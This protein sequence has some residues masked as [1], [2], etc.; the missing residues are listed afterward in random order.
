MSQNVILGVTGSIAAYKAAELAS[1]LV[2][3][4]YAVHVIMTPAATRFITPLTLQA[5]SQNPV[6][7]DMFASPGLGKSGTSAWQDVPI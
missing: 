1:L 4:N 7:V 3:R 2:K 5:I 6:H